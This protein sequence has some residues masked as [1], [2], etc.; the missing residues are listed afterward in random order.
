MADLNHDADTRTSVQDG[1]LTMDD[2]LEPVDVLEICED[3]V[4]V[5]LNRFMVCRVTAAVL[6]RVYHNIVHFLHSLA[7]SCVF[8][9]LA[10]VS[11]APLAL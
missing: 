9:H 6:P 10:S 5:T 4:L 2:I 3:G 11:F 1:A 8:V 7:L